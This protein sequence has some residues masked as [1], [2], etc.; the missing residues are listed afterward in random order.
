MPRIV[1]PRRFLAGR[2]LA[3]SRGN[4][5]SCEECHW[6]GRWRL[7]HA[8]KL[9]CAPRCFLGH[10]IET[11][12]SRSSQEAGSTRLPKIF[13]GRNSCGKQHSTRSNPPGS[14]LILKVERCFSFWNRER[15]W[16]SSWRRCYGPLSRKLLSNDLQRGKEWR[17]A[18]PHEHQTVG[19]SPVQVPNL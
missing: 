9:C 7:R 11:V 15:L 13:L 18:S 17:P 10:E 6:D 8:P 16:M 12:E 1:L 5:T 19:W 3:D 4:T 2:P 14:I